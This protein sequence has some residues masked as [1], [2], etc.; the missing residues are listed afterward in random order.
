MTVSLLVKH[1][2]DLLSTSEDAEQLSNTILQLA[3]QGKLGTQDSSDEPASEILKRIRT[4]RPDSEKG[5][6]VR[7]DEIPFPLPK[8]W[9]WVR[10]PEVT[11]N[12][13]QKKPEKQ[14]TYIDVSSI[15]NQFGI[16][17]DELAI[18]NPENAPSRARKI[19]KEGSV[20]YS[21]V[22]PYLLNIAI[23][24]RDIQPEPIVSTAFYVMH[25]AEGLDAKFLY[26][27]LRSKYFTKFVES[28]MTGMAYPAI[29]DGKMSLGIIP[30]PPYAEQQRIVARVEELFA[31]TRALAKEL[32]HS[33]SEL[34]SL[35]KSALSHLLASETPE[36]FDQ[37]WAFIAEHF[38]LLFQ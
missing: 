13:G 3:M 16:V 24:D 23:I 38:G 15:D 22:R 14:F 20:I 33:Q 6:T 36:E 10:L 9:E 21:T 34:D 7:E 2:D 19:V 25:P 8:G 18:L 29:N 31:Q 11:D 28:Q 35:N 17:S 5:L 1:F 37:H 32:D 30:L 12:W 4:S 26:L 27:Y